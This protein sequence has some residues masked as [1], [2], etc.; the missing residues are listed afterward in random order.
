[1]GY[2][3]NRTFAVNRELASSL[4]LHSHYLGAALGAEWTVLPSFELAARVGADT[5]PA[6]LERVHAYF[7]AVLRPQ[8]LT[9]TTFFARYSFLS[10]RRSYEPVP[11]A[12]PQAQH[13]AAIGVGSELRPQQL[14]LTSS[15]GA[16][17][18]D[19][20]SMYYGLVRLDWS[21]ATALEL[22]ADYRLNWLPPRGELAAAFVHWVSLDLAYE[23]TPFARAGVV[24]GARL[25]R[26]AAA[27]QE[28][29]LL[30]R[31]QV[32]Y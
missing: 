28:Y 26:D 30:A 21:A 4:D 22:G 14:R 16:E 13:L 19:L 12:G 1:V 15:V 20:L 25:Q 27:F 5:G 18:G 7:E 6:L 31:F 17:L 29:Q 11:P 32:H 24:A 10:D 9:A 23:L 8:S 3:L 2:E